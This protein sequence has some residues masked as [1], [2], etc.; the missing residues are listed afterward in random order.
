MKHDN[1]KEENEQELSK[2]NE[3]YGRASLWVLNLNLS[4]IPQSGTS[5][6]P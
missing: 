2:N 3:E 5:P 6:P 1:R 4:F